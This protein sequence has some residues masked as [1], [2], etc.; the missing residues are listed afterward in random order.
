MTKH[1]YGDIPEDIITK[2]M[3]P[4]GEHIWKVYEDLGWE[5][6]EKQLDK[7]TAVIEGLGDAT[8]EK[9]QTAVDISKEVLNGS[10]KNPDKVLATWFFPPLV[11]VRSD[12]QMGTTKLI[13]GNSTDITFLILN[14]INQEVELIINA[15]C[16]NGIPVDYWYISESGDSELFHRRHQKYGVKLKDMAKK[17]KDSVTSGLRLIDILKDVRNERTPEFSKSAYSLCMVWVTSGLNVSIEPSNF[18]AMG[19]VWDGLEAKNTYGMKD[20]WF[21]YVPMVSLL[22]MMAIS[23]RSSWIGKVT[24][25]LTNNQL[26]INAFE[27]K[28]KEVYQ[29]R[30]PELWKYFFTII[31]KNG[32]PSPKMSVGCKPPLLKNEKTYRSSQFIWEYPEGEKIYP[33]EWDLTDDQLTAGIYT[34]ITIDTKEEDLSKKERILSLGIGTK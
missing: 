15:H 11:Y 22:K 9:F 23:G 27:P 6:F 1:N 5:Y 24:G 21:N 19:A 20:Y 17:S 14:D 7:K 31:K 33:E 18:G 29:N 12:L 30:A 2:R 25:L 10:I 3:L 8:N 4:L 26:F 13:Y 16:E 34:D 28:H 32:I